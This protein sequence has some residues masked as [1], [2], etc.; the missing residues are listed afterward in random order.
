[1]FKNH[2]AA[3]FFEFSI[4][5]IDLS[6]NFFSSLEMKNNAL[7]VSMDSKQLCKVTAFS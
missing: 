1:M 7:F 4:T 5:N 2:L 6:A 3:S